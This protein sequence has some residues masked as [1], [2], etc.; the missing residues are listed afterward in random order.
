MLKRPKVPMGDLALILYRMHT[1][2]LRIP[3][4]SIYGMWLYI[5]A[6]GLLLGCGPKDPTARILKDFEEKF[7]DA[8]QVHWKDY[9]GNWEATFQWHGSTYSALYDLDDSWIQTKHQIKLEAAPM[10]VREVFERHYDV[11]YL[12][13]VLEVE[14]P[15]ATYYEF[16]MDTLDETYRVIYDAHGKFF[17]REG[18]LYRSLE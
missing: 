16:N 1:K 11:E 12:T 4:H 5:M 18:E 17:E 15:R 13:S 3:H 14:M 10:L 9:Q 8:Q 2:T 7:A 6:M